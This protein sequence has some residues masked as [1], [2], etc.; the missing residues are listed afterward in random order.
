MRDE[1]V[2]GDEGKAG[3]FIV[4]GVEGNFKGNVVCELLQIRGRMKLNF[5]K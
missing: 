1:L 3:N 4:Y 2:V 5:Y